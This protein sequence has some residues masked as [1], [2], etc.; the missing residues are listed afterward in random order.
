MQEGASVSVAEKQEVDYDLNGVNLLVYFVVIACL[1]CY[2][3]RS[4]QLLSCIQ[5]LGRLS[6]SYA[7]VGQKLG[8]AFP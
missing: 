7:L 2:I 3:Q 5:A 1:T 8:S 6:R 4:V